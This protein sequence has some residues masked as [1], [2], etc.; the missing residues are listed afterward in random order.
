MQNVAA[1]HLSPC[2]ESRHPPLQLKPSLRLTVKSGAIIGADMA[3]ETFKRGQVEWA[4]WRFFT[5]MKSAPSN[6]PKVFLTRIKRLLETDRDNKVPAGQDFEPE[7]NFAFSSAEGDGQGVDA[8]FTPFDAFCLALA[9]DFTD[10]GFKPS[11]IVFL[12][13]HLR[14]ELE[15]QFTEILRKPPPPPR[16]RQS[17]KS[18]PGLTTY[19]SEGKDWV[20]GRVFWV[21]QKVELKEIYGQTPGRG[22]K[23]EAP[24]FLNPTF[25]HGIEELARQLGEMNTTRVDYRKAL[26]LEI[27]NL[28]SELTAILAEAPLMRRGRK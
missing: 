18:R 10:L 12:L 9:L 1:P 6:P 26:V 7:A 19:R 21:I 4:M 16:R 5:F 2:L 25:C 14:S 27:A 17:A 28:A 8:I 24:I 20:D 3:N 11:E 13:R 23:K 15:G 22:K